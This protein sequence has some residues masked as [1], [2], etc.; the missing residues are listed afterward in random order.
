MAKVTMPAPTLEELQEMA[1]AAGCVVR[2][3]K[4][5]HFEVKSIR[6]G[7]TETAGTA[8]DVLQTALEIGGKHDWT[9]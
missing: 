7:K 9:A 3:V 6:T 5:G 1:L 2:V 8:S 4:G